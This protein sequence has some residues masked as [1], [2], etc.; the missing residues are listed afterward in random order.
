M[1]RGFSTL[2]ILIAMAILIS[3][4]VVTVLLSSS[5]S[6]S[7]DAQTSAE[8]LT[9]ARQALE[10]EQSLARKDFKL[11]VA[12]SS[13]VT[14]TGTT[15]TRVISVAIPSA[16]LDPLYAKQVTATVTWPGTYGRHPSTALTTIVTNFENAVGGDTCSTVFTNA[17][18]ANGWKTPVV[19]NS[20]LATL[21]GDATPNAPYPISDI[22]MYQ[23][24]LYVAVSGSAT[25][26]GPNN[27]S[28]VAN[29]TSTGSVSWT[30]TSNA[31]VTDGS[32][33]TTNLN[34]GQTSNYLKAT[35]FGTFSIPSWATITG[36]VVTIQRK[37][38]S[39]TNTVHDS[40]VRIVRSDGSYGSQNKADTATNWPT[41]TASNTYGSSSD[42]WGESWTP[43]TINNIGV[44][45]SAVAASGSG[46]RTASVDSISI[47]VYY[48]R[49]FYIL[50][51]NN[52]ASPSYLGTLATSSAIGLN[53]IAVATSSATNYAYA[54]TSATVTGQLEILNVANPTTSFVMST[55]PTA[56]GTG[57]GKGVGTSLFYQ[58]GYLYEGLTTGTGGPEFNIIDV[59]NPTSPSWKGGY[60]VGNTVNAI[61]VKDGYAYL[62]TNDT[63]KELV[64]LNVTNPASPT[65][66]G[67][68]NAMPDITNFGYGR[69]LYTVGD[70]VYLGR[71]WT[72]SS[73]IPQFLTLNASAMPVVAA[74]S[75]N[76]KSLGTNFSLNGIIARDSLIFLLT[77]SQ[78]SGGNLQIINATSTAAVATVSLPGAT[79]TNNLGGTALDCEGNYVYAASVD[80]AGKGYITSVTGQ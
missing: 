59:S 31:K 24:R 47:T 39:S 56:A 70:T 55:F 63:T 32:F 41:S 45:I 25:A 44:A 3:A 30:N 8:A 49:Q 80:A 73:S 22:D 20:T 76:S 40:G 10:N 65:L 74:S 29:D 6:V 78:N 69:A 60:T 42:L 1:K 13:T 75:P 17:G 52:P 79:G 64:I 57:M 28:T 5:Q 16:P 71:S 58:N 66:I 43:T 34:S 14:V 72:N 33:A 38:S 61:V 2:E 68:Y 48:S 36:I 9:L 21:V 11:V 77:G 15:Y 67:T 37:G 26:V 19:T 4:F 23:K 18:G 62:S 7:V 12:T 27:P 51:E 35:S 46:T 54:A 50:N 53:A